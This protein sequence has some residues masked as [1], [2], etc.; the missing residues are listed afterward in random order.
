MAGL[1]CLQS[2][3]PRHGEERGHN[4]RAKLVT[5]FINRQLV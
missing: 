1:L 2:L 4:V 5:Y 3:L